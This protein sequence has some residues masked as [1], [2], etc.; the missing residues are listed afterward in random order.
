MAALQLGQLSPCMVTDKIL[1]VGGSECAVEEFVG[2]LEVRFD[3]KEMLGG[4]VRPARDVQAV[5]SRFTGGISHCWSRAWRASLD[6]GT[7][8]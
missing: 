2:R 3:C 1:K 8:V 4:E 7:R 5:L 6:S